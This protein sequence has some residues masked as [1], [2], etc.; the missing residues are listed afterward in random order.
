M[1]ASFIFFLVLFFVPSIGFSDLS[2]EEVVVKINV[3]GAS[4]NEPIQSAVVTIQRPNGDRIT[5]S[6][7]NKGQCVFNAEYPGE[8]LIKVEDGLHEDKEVTIEVPQ[9]S[10]QRQVIDK[11]ILLK[12]KDRWKFIT[13]HQ[14]S[15]YYLVPKEIHTA[16]VGCGLPFPM[17]FSTDTY[18]SQNNLDSLV[19]KKADLAIIQEDVVISYN[20]KNPDKPVQ[21]VFPMFSEHFHFL[22]L[23]TTIAKDSLKSVADFQGKKVIIGAPVGSG[24]LFT[25]QRIKKLI[26]ADWEIK[27]LGR[28]FFDDLVEPFYFGEIDFLF[29]TAGVPEK[30]FREWDPRYKKFDLLPVILPDLTEYTQDTIPGKE[31]WWLEKDVP[32]Y[33]LQAMIFT[34]SDNDFS[35]EI[36]KKFIETL[37]NPC[38]WECVKEYHCPPDLI[39][40]PRFWKKTSPNNFKPQDGLILHPYLEE[41]IE[42]WDED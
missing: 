16:A 21:M 17:S 25:L 27:E 26:N 40:H 38:V 19:H 29:F 14:T 7:D 39:P 23:K 32:T 33:S 13:A 9:M 20:K 1:K 28:D 24:S 11:T 15:S 10:T 12:E 5:L 35:D 42:D 41:I 6:T 22:G 18:G 37:L 30:L 4:S 31:Y 2:L 3:K 34:Y 8:Y 36:G